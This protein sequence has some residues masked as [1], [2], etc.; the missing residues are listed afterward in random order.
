[1]RGALFGEDLRCGT[2][3]DDESFFE[4]NDFGVEDE[5]LFDV[6]GDG[7]DGNALLRGVLLHAGK[8]DV[9]QRAIDAGEGF[10]EED[11][12][13]GGDGEGSGQVDALAFAAGEIAGKAVS[14]WSELK[15]IER[16]VGGGRIRL[17]TDVGCEG[18]VLA[19]GEVGEEDGALRSVREVAAVGR[20]LVER[21]RSV[22][23]AAEGLSELH[24][25]GKDEAA[26]GAQDGT[27]AAARGSKED[28]PG[29]R[30]RHKCGDVQR[31]EVRV[32]AEK[33]VGLRQAQTSGCR[34]RRRPA[35]LGMRVR[36]VR[37][38]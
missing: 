5:G 22:C 13:R 9:A 28:G 16:Y 12:V 29:C 25:G 30:Q 36:R 1:M 10:V 33:V 38:R 35:G 15:E 2:L 8:Q 3:V 4:T 26:G 17:V 27:L 11:E 31:S 20:D 23:C 24:V 18:D 19:D 37:R 34:G 6:V 32:D 14:E 21:L 7:E